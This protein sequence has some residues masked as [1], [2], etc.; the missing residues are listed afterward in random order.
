MLAVSLPTKRIIERLFE[1]SNGAQP[2]DRSEDVWWQRR[3]RC[4]LDG[5]LCIIWLTACSACLQLLALTF[6]CGTRARSPT[7]TPPRHWPATHR[8]LRI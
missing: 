6:C 5:S 2:D 4:A 7:A 3:P 8:S 1:L